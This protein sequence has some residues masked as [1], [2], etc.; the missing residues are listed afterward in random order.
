MNLRRL[1]ADVGGT[2]SRF[3][4]SDGPGRLSE[5]RIYET[6]ARPTFAGTMAAY[7]ADIGAEPAGAAW[8]RDVRVAAAGPVDAGTVRLTNSAWQIS[9]EEISRDFGGVPVVLVNDLEAVGLLLPHLTPADTKPVG[10][11]TM[12]PPGA[13]LVGNRIAVNIGT[14]FGAATAVRSISD[15]S[16]TRWTIA[17][18]EAGHM[19]LAAVTPEEAAALAFAHSVEDVLSGAGVSRLYE[20]V[21]STTNDHRTANAVFAGAASDPF[22]AVTVQIL[23]RLLG[24]IAGDLVLA[25]ASWDG[26]YLCGTVAQTWAGVGDTAAFR[27]EFERKGAMSARMAKVPAHVITA[28][29]PAL[30]GLSYADAESG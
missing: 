17:A 5:I 4:V 11:A 21:A 30:L 1:V 9:A 16:G 13:G 10:S 18:G 24:R 23:S 27:A 15:K 2:R 19:T 28:A 22:A 25:T 6:A 8:C 14:G 29:E 3:G 26:V 20:A 12:V 7:L